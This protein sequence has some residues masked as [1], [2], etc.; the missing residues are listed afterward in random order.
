MILSSA[1]NSDSTIQELTPTPTLAAY[2]APAELEKMP[3][4]VAPET[5]LPSGPT[6][7]P[8][9]HIVQQ[10]E[11]LLGIAIRYGVTLDNLLLVNPGVDPRIL[12][13]GQNVA[14]PGPSGEPIDLL[15]PT[16]T[17]APLDLGEV[18][19]YPGRGEMIWCLAEASNNTASGIEG[20]GVLISLFDINGNQVAQSP[21]NSLTR[22]LPP[23]RSAI[24]VAAFSEPLAPPFRALVDQISGVQVSNLEERLIE[25]QIRDL[26]VDRAVG[27]QLITFSGMI[28]LQADQI[29]GVV[30]VTLQI[31]GYNDAGEPNASN[32][33]Q[34]SIELITDPIPFQLSLYSL[35]GEIEDFSILAEVQNKINRE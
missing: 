7:T 3:V 10:G 25:A 11:T 22:F 23:D 19:C 31:F 6:A 8:F 30:N 9:V 13:V 28:E 14:I 4:L 5:P 26:K 2:I 34:T 33:F 29:Q 21:A 16:P 24:L 17:P 15:L 20:L 12:S 1:C 35:G 27:N 32:A 18:Y